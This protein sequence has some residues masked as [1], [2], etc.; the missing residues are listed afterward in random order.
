MDAPHLANT[1]P[2][3]VSQTAIWEAAVMYPIDR[4]VP[5]YLAE[6][7]MLMRQQHELNA[8]GAQFSAWV[9]EAN[10]R[11]KLMRERAWEESRRHHVGRDAL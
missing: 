6:H 7:R 4:G 1:N 8:L 11:E 3:F 2:I 5:P 10:K 9:I